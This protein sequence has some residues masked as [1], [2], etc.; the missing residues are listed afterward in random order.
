[1]ACRAVHDAHKGHTSESRFE[2]S[3]KGGA[4]KKHFYIMAGLVPTIDVFPAS[5]QDVD[6]RDKRQHD[7]VNTDSHLT[8][9]RHAQGRSALA[10]A[11]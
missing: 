3:A 7:A 4:A 5:R 11:S 6:V 9:R 1:M 10:F 8:P 2:N